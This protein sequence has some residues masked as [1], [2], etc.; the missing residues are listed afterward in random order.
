[1]TNTGYDIQK[2]RR[3]LVDDLNDAQLALRHFDI[4]NNRKV[5]RK[6]CPC[7]QAT[8]TM[9]RIT[10]IEDKDVHEALKDVGII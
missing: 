5:H 6:G 9:A 8:C 3:M 4:A 10:P 7:P 2:A 1:M